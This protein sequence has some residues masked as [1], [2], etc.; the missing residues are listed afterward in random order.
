MSPPTGSDREL[1]EQLC[2]YRALY[3]RRGERDATVVMTLADAI[4]HANRLMAEPAVPARPD[5]RR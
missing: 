2:R 4:Q 3:V 1:F 5:A